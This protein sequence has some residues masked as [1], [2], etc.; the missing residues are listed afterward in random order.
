LKDRLKKGDLAV[1]IFHDHGSRYVGKIYNDQWMIERGFLEVKTFRD[2][3]NGRGNKQK[4]VTVS[5]DNTVA[6]A[7]ELMKKY[8]IENLPVLSNDQFVG[9]VSESGLFHKLLQG[10]SLHQT[11]VETIVEPAYPIVDM[12]TPVERLS[13]MIDKDNGAIMAKD[14]GGQFHIVTKYDVIQS[15]R[16]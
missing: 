2:L 8:H 13:T 1:L 11:K 14:E 15:L 6:E 10:I 4:L 7:V 9:S 5:T 16:S 12:E 3:V